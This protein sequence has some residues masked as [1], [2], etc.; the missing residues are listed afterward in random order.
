MRWFDVGL[1]AGSGLDRGASRL[2]AWGRGRQVLGDLPLL[3]TLSATYA[4]RPSSE[5]VAVSWLTLGAGLGA[6]ST[7]TA[8]RVDLRV[9]MELMVAH[10]R[11]QVRDEATGRDDS[12]DTWS[13]GFL[14][15]L[16]AAWPHASPAALVVGVDGWTLARR[17]EILVGDQR[18]ASSPSIGMT[19]LIGAEFALP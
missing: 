10:V 13:G 4:V 3:V 16:G 9:H 14:G 8:V 1:L 17:T 7:W 15:G 12:G 2:G 6:H 19:F 5:Q 11:A 18:F